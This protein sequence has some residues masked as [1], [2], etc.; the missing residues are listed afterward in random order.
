MVLRAVSE[1]DPAVLLAE[2][3]ANVDL[4]VVSN[5]GPIECRIDED[6]GINHVRGAGGVAAALGYIAAIAPITWV[7]SAIV[8]GDRRIAKAYDSLSTAQLR[9]IGMRG[10]NITP[11]FVILPLPVYRKYYQDFSNRILW[12]LQHYMWNSSY[13]P[14][15]DSSTYDAWRT[16]YVPANQRFADKV[17]EVISN[18]RKTP[19]IL[20]QDYH[21]YLTPRMVRN[22][23][24]TSIIQ[25]FTHIPWPE[26]RYW[27][28]LPFEMR[29]DIFRGLVAA[30]FLGFQT[31][32]DARNFV[33]GCLA[34]LRGA[35]MDRDAVGVLLDGHVAR[36]RAYPISVDP[37]QLLRRARS[38]LVKRY[39]AQ[40][41]PICGEKTIVRV[42]RLEPSKNIL[43]GLQAY[44]ALL[45]GDPQL[46][47]RV[48]LLLFLVPSREQITEYR[49]YRSRV[50]KMIDSVNAKHGREGWRPIEVFYENNYDQALAGLSLYDVLLVNPMIDGMNLV[51]KEGP[52]VNTKAGVL[53]L[54]EG[55][56]AYQQL[57][58]GVVP[59]AAAD[60]QGTRQALQF[61]LQMSQPERKRRAAILKKAIEREDLRHWLA[62]QLGEIADLLNRLGFQT[63]H[64]ARSREA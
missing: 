64:A 29:E 22:G 25:H 4:T 44:D 46:I 41:Q 19:V 63:R 40:L 51:A 11:R 7:F 3:S 36:V 37:G 17:V 58:E 13:E 28:M 35:R 33:D 9:S 23:A 34:F 39:V 49:R 24:P 57:R 54:T 18:S 5:R 59:V 42:D 16:G 30:D 32:Q 14:R 21:L 6:E 43:R 47:G 2:F 15:I 62:S 52:I 60:V 31:T 61:A 10:N 48:K 53:V 45:S 50:V 38:P 26:P 20:L 56:G 8:Q 27:E 12:F 55:A 1:P